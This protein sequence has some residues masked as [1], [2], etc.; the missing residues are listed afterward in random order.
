M[1]SDLQ[2]SWKK[3][4]CHR[5][6]PVNFPKFLRPFFPTENLWWLLLFYY[7]FLICRTLVFDFAKM[8]SLARILSPKTQRS[9]V[10]ETHVFELTTSI[11]RYKLKIHPAFTIRCISFMIVQ[12]WS[13]LERHLINLIHY[14][15]GIR[16]QI[17]PL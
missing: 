10:F 2:I 17:Y 1:V 4:L 14:R 12:P 3:G 13:Q 6:F 8:E 5:C 16:I 11:F 9:I 15:V 7:V